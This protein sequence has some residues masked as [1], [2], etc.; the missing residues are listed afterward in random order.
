L[1][2]SSPTLAV[3]EAGHPARRWIGIALILVVA[4]A[5]LSA[6]YKL[7]EQ[8]DY[9]ELLHAARHADPRALFWSFV[10]TF[11]SFVALAARDWFA[12]EFIDTRLSWSA[13][14]IASF[15]GNALGNV[16]GFGAL[17]GGAIRYR[18]YSAV[19]VPPEAVARIT[20]FL[21]YGF[22]TG[23]ACLGG[24]SLVSMAGP[25]AQVIHVDPFWIR[26]LGLLSLAAG[27]FV[28]AMGHTGNFRWRRWEASF[29]AAGPVS[30]QAFLTAVDI[31]AAGAALWVLLPADSVGFATFSA[32]YAV[33]IS[34]G[35]I[36]QVPGGLGVFDAL[37][38]VTLEGRITPAALAGCLLVYR[39]MYFG[40]PLLV[41][42]AVL[43]GFELRV[44]SG[45]PLTPAAL[46]VIRSAAQLSPAFLGVIAFGVGVVLVVSGATPTFGHRLVA[47]SVHVPLFFLEAS[48][49]L[50]SL[51]GILL[52]FVARGLFRRLDGAWW[53]ALAISIFSLA[54]SLTKGLAYGEAGLIA[55]MLAM[56]LATRKQFTRKASL[57]SQAFSGG[58]FLAL[59]LIL[60]GGIWILL[61]SFRDVA[62]T[63]DL[64]WQFEFDAQAPRALRA[65]VGMCVLAVVIGVWN[66]LRTS[67]GEAQLPTP[68]EVEQARTI[69]ERQNHADALLA[70]MGDKSLMF[71]A[72]RRS[73]L[74]YARRGRSW[75]SLFDPVGDPADAAELIWRF[76]ELAA[77]HGG[78]AAFYQVRAEALPLY[79]DAG[80]RIVKLGEEAR[81]D[82]AKFSLQGSERANL[83]H[84]IKRG[85]REGLA[86]ELHGPD[87]IADVVDSVRLV[88]S[89]W[90]A[91]RRTGEK[92]FSVAAF[93]SRF[94]SAQSL[95]VARSG[96]RIV[97]FTSVMS[98]Q[99]GGECVIGLM[100]HATDAPGYAMEF[101][102]T[103]LILALQQR[104]YSW[105]S[106][107]MAPL[108]GFEP[109][110]LASRWNRLALLVSRHGN[111]AYNFQGLRVFKG[112][113][114]PEWVPRY[115][116]ASGTFGPFIVIADAAALVTGAFRGALE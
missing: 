3:S 16:A 36:S 17:T 48:H 12:L 110:P 75:I 107:G 92:G 34:L 72:S 8:I 76:T 13:V 40:L 27:I 91:A 37:I 87:T 104:G 116:A 99:A 112:K 70:L 103:K 60:A 63:H 62:Y 49:F 32:I 59:A 24:L 42:G 45:R 10:A 2:T 96:D 100:R 78:R 11:V 5:G 4:A 102:F 46:G 109:R 61:F 33:A 50:G 98:A 95:A 47:L 14:G 25:V 67:R 74:M 51:L 64:W 15:C 30:I 55:T 21:A 26:L 39:A 113:F 77:G 114:R 68:E 58:W 111:V 65:I 93:E 31:V 73:F 28:I 22:V 86:F 19:G 83:R 115:L 1:A 52:L 88:S 84:A 23:M 90:L 85:E 82:L 57:L 7:T 94:V 80:L 108:S 35:I 41:S 53:L 105:L 18:I 43:A 9:H 79:L 54:F 38:L 56:L 106:L 89:E 6:A 81:V 71:S 69:I 66:L 44:R 29:P 20:V 97:A 101:L